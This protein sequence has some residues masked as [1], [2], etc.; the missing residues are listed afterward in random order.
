MYSFLLKNKIVNSL[1]LVVLLIVLRIVHFVYPVAEYQGT[2]GLLYTEWFASTPMGA[3]FW[4]TLILIFQLYCILL[5]F[6]QLKISSESTLI[7]GLVFV[8]F[9]T[10]IPEM[11]T[12]Q[13]IIFAN[14]MLLVAAQQ[15]LSI[16]PRSSSGKEVFNAGVFLA[17]ATLFYGSYMMFIVAAVSGI[18]I[19]RSWRF[20]DIKILLLGYLTPF[21]L[22]GVYY[23]WFD[24]L[25]YFFTSLFN[26][27]GIVSFRYFD[28]YW[29]IGVAAIISLIVLSSILSG[30]QVM[31][32]KTNT[33]QN[34]FKI[35][36]WFLFSCLL[37][38]L[39]QTQI[40]IEHSLVLAIPLS[41]IISEYLVNWKE[42]RARFAVNIF[43][44]MIILY[45]LRHFIL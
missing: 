18:N 31:T 32:K 44:V 24:K 4:I 40:G 6:L 34:Y 13:P 1:L 35:A 10:L 38:S 25:G 17:L 37:V 19:I 12:F 41:F 8:L 14:T 43:L 26:G 16:S 36:Y 22:V 21:F 29:H 42:I 5:I 27:I 45:Q 11:G 7:P 9:V 20:R 23:F 2:A 15:L 30:G 28:N 3:W 33:K 39:I